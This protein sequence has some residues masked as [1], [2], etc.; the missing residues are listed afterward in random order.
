MSADI[1]MRHYFNSIALKLDSAGH[2]ERGPILDEVQ[3]FLGCSRQTIYRQL[4]QL[5]GWS[6]KRKARS[7]KGSTSMSEE[8]LVALAAMSR[9]SIRD[10]GKQ[11]LFT[12]T[13]RGIL[14]QNGFDINLSNTQINR[15]LRQRKLDTKSQKVAN[16]VQSL[17]GLYPNYAHEVDPSLCLIYYMHGKQRVMREREFYKNKLENFAKVKFKV[18]RYTLYDRASGMIIPWYV[19]AAGENQY[20]LFQ[21]LMFAWGKQEGRLFHGVPAILYWDKGSANTSHSIKNLLDHLEVKY[22]EHEAGNARAKGGVENA[23]NIIET[24]FES[25]LRFEPVNDI[26]QLNQSALVWA[27]AYNANLLPGQ[28]TRLRRLG[29]EEAVSRQSLW[30]YITA[31]QLRTLPSLEVCKALMTSK[32][33]ER[34]VKPDLT[35]TFKHPQAGQSL[36]YS[37]KGLEGV[38]VK[39]NILVRALVYGDCAIQI[40]VNRYDGAPLTYRVEPERDFDKFGQRLSAAIIGEEFKSQSHTLIEYAAKQM[41]ALA[42]PGQSED[43][44]KKSRAKQA[45]PFGGK[46]NAHSYLNDIEHPI[47]LPKNGLEI[48][49]PEHLTSSVSLVSVTAAM[50]RITKAIGRSLR[51]EEH[52]WLSKRYKDGIPEDNVDS[53]IQLFKQ[54]VQITQHNGTTGLKLV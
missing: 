19:E 26:A 35:I 11:T 31:E 30:Q 54:P 28:D 13:A 50:L 36:S 43:E 46:L 49:T 27:E 8:A 17:R 39:D 21:F 40:Q 14:E 32:E 29:L 45:V 10:N 47:Y 20:S 42:Y 51:T 34:Q 25:R 33:Q 48:A 41:D 3:A 37:L 18:W 53:V 2:G 15:L 6:T 24:Q 12:S 1:N 22:F 38:A 16:P 5:C 52:Q 44:V 7:D 23:N 9:E 4:K